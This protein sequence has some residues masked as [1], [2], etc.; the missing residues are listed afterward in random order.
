MRCPSDLSF[1]SLCDR[2]GKNQITSDDV[3]FFESRVVTDEIPEEMDNENFKTGKCQIIVT[4]NDDRDAVNHSKL[5]S[6]LP[7]EKEYVC[8]TKD[9]VTNRKTNIP[10]PG[11]RKYKRTQGMMN[12]LII[13]EGAP[14]MMTTNHSTPR[15]KEDGLTNGSFGYIDFIQ[16]SEEDPDKVEIIWVVFRDKRVGRKHYK[17]E[18]RK[19]RTPDIAHLIHENAL[20]ILPSK[21]PFEVKQGGLLYIRKQ[22]PLTLAPGP[23]EYCKIS[24]YSNFLQLE[25]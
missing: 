10:V 2:V 13:R 17:G 19:W 22:F 8:L 12:N 16:F 9:N 23:D 15:F 3:Q 25:L 24:W 4:T 11:A 7:S 18:M 20:P 1:A 14:V 5:R 21:K 6:L